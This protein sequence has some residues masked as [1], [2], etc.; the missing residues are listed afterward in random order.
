MKTQ[1]FRETK[2][3]EKSRPCWY[4]SKLEFCWI[5]SVQCFMVIVPFYYSHSNAD[6]WDAYNPS[7]YITLTQRS[8][9]YLKGAKKYLKLN[10]QPSIPFIIHAMFRPVH[11][12][13][14]RDWCRY[15]NNLWLF[16]RSEEWLVWALCQILAAGLLLCWLGYEDCNF[17]QKKLFYLFLSKMFWY[18]T[19][20]RKTQ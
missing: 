13:Q 9:I 6:L 2:I 5:G 8:E 14:G 3:Q 11:S 16:K 10:E 15:L 4:Q 12:D 19:T 17:G 1:R 20:V 7:S 18:L